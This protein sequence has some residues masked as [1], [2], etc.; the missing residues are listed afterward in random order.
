VTTHSPFFPPP[1]LSVAGEMYSRGALRDKKEKRL[2]SRGY[3]ASIF[4]AL[5]DR[6]LV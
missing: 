1:A 5:Q 2:V 4:S 3:D 6:I